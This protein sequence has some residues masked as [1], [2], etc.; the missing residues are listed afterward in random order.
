MLQMVVGYRGSAP[1]MKGLVC[2]LGVS[3]RIEF[4]AAPANGRCQWPVVSVL[5]VGC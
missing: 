2:P 1:T 5:E 3:A 4:A